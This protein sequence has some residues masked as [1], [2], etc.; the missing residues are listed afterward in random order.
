L[1]DTVT[2]EMNDD[3]IPGK[4]IPFPAPVPTAD[5]EGI[6]ARHHVIIAVG[7]SRYEVDVLAFVTALQP[8]MAEGGRAVQWMLTGSGV[9]REAAVL[10]QVKEWSQSRRQGWKAVLKLEGEKKVWEAY[11]RRLGI[12]G[13]SPTAAAEQSAKIPLALWPWRSDESTCAT[14]ARKEEV[15][16]T[17]AEN[18][19]TMPQQGT[20]AGNAGTKAEA[21][22]EDFLSQAGTHFQLLTARL[23]TYGYDVRDRLGE[24]RF[25]RSP[26]I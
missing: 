2:V 18:R 26:A 12:A 24:A 10:V 16:M 14:S 22:K 3:R 23:L 7:N 6:L 4:V 15:P 5:T 19:D 13:D 21:S 9:E 1:V 8:A 11:W 20:T 25:Y 17:N